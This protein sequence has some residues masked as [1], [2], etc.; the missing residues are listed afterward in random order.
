MEAALSVS[1]IEDAIRDLIVAEASN[2]GIEVS[3]PVAYPGGDLVSVVIEQTKEGILIHDA[4]FAAMR[5]SQ[6][7]IQISKAVGV[8]LTEYAARFNCIYSLGRVSVRCD[9]DS[10]GVTAAL[11]ANAARS[12]ADYALEI[13]RHAEAD[14]RHILSD[15]LREIVGPRLRENEEI[16]GK[17]GRKYRISAVLL[18]A[19]EANP[20]NFVS[21]VANRQAVPLGFAMLYDLR[22]SFV[23]VENDSVYD[24]A[25]D[26]REE[27]RALLSSVGSVFGFM[28]AKHRFRALLGSPAGIG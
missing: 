22:G 27:D 14:F 15:V 7:G 10:V 11:V 19:A 5:L 28:E 13:K 8:R 20:L 6:S 25:S 23:G 9:S 3:V 12:V 26:I 24:D 1:Q 16:K 4:G 2:L 21:A 17:S 18:D